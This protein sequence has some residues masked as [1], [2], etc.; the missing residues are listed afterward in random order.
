MAHD[1]EWVHK[2]RFHLFETPPR[3][4]EEFHP[5]IPRPPWDMP[6]MS[7]PGMEL[8]ILPRF[9][10]RRTLPA[11]SAPRS[12]SLSELCR[13]NRPTVGRLQNGA[14]HFDSATDSSGTEPPANSDLDSNAA[15]RIG[16]ATPTPI[17]HPATPG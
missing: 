15:S 9:T 11:S 5:V 3:T 14:D 8:P 17:M 2:D 6:F 1:L 13:L 16:I 4:S 12:V 7:N 10:G